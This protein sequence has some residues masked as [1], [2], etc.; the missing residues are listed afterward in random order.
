MNILVIFGLVIYFIVFMFDFLNLFASSGKFI[1]SFVWS[2]LWPLT[3]VFMLAVTLISMLNAS[4]G[5]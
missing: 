5:R 3:M 2:A 1:R 4:R